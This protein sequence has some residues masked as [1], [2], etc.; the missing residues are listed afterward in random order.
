M[1][2]SSADDA[3]GDVHERLVDQCESFET[4]APS[5]EGVESGEWALNNASDFA[6]ATA[7]RVAPAGDFRVT[8]PAACGGLRYTALI[9]GKPPNLLEPVA[10]LPER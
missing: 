3:A 7:M 5:R 1:K 2:L 6:G 4:S 10:S 8:L 9:T